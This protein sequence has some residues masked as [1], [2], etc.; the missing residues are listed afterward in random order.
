MEPCSIYT[1]T[2]KMVRG[3]I[4]GD[5]VYPD[6]PDALFDDFLCPYLL[7]VESG[8]KWGLTHGHTGA[9][10]VP[11]QFDAAGPLINGASHAVKN[12]LHGYIDAQ[13]ETVLPFAYADAC[14]APSSQGYFAV[15]G[16]RWGG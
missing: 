2:G 15:K 8:G 9:L 11:L 6:T 4:A 16:E 10:A 5:R 13:G 12:G 14:R 1:I 3:L 7:P